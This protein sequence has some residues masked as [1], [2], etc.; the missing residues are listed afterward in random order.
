[1]EFL[2]SERNSELYPNDPLAPA[3]YQPSYL[4]AITMF[5]DPLAWF[6]NTG[7]SS[8]FVVDASPIISS[9][10][11]ERE[12]IYRGTILP[13][14][15]VPDGVSWTGFASVADGQRGGYLLAFRELNA[16]STWTVPPSIFEAGN[17]HKQI[18][19][20]EGKVTQTSDTFL[21][22]IQKPLGFVWARLDIA[23]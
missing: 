2:N 15:E 21:V 17:Y 8:R 9:W 18:L 3:R 13:I 7:L 23:H 12:A 20:G 4:F 22:D 6:E 14:G 10:K 11:E 5:G 16:H 1:M 19:G